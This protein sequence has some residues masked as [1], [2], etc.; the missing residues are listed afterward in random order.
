LDNFT[1]FRDIDT[2]E[3]KDEY[4]IIRGLLR[5][6]K[7]DSDPDIVQQLLFSLANLDAMLSE[8]KVDNEISHDEYID[9][10]HKLQEEI[11]LSDDLREARRIAGLMFRRMTGYIKEHGIFKA[12]VPEKGLKVAYVPPEK[13]VKR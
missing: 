7:S 4:D 13:V 12:E 2:E 11:G 8:T 10:I 5:N 1:P 3:L 6:P 9:D